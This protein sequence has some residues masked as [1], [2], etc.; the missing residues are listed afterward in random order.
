MRGPYNQLVIYTIF[1]QVNNLKMKPAG[2]Y[3]SGFLG[4][5]MLRGST[6]LIVTAS[7]IVSSCALSRFAIGICTTGK[8]IS[9]LLR[10]CN[11]TYG[12][13]AA[14]CRELGSATPPQ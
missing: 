12:S 3:V 4:D 9:P 5:T 13:L 14:R 8:N 6:S 11:K 2:L 1:I 7:I 10:D